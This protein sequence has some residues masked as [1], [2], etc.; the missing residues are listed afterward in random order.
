MYQNP[1]KDLKTL[2]AKLLITKGPKNKFA[3]KKFRGKLKFLLLKNY[4]VT[5]FSTASFPL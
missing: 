5:C 3:P 4:A 1:L 2:L